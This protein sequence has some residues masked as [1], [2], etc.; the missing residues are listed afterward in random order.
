[1]WMSTRNLGA[2]LALVGVVAGCGSGSSDSP[3]AR[4]AAV[5]KAVSASDT[6]S[7]S[8][9]NAVAD[10]KGEPVPVQVKFQL[11]SRPDVAQSLEIDLAIVP[12]SGSV[13]RIVGTIQ[14]EDGLDLVDGD[15]IAV[16][17]RSLEGVPITHTVHVLPKRDGIFTLSAVLTID[18]A[19]QSNRET[20]SIPVIAG[21]GMPDL[22]SKPSSDTATA[23]TAAPATPSGKPVRPK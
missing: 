15:K 4:H 20:Y 8:M 17:D 9:V 23:A 22:P 3:G 7:R 5:R 1:M 21:A 11:A 10:P 18:S 2:L 6:A 16:A 12:I 13:D 14:S 19:G